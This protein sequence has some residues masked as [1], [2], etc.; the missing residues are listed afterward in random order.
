M[1]HIT[2]PPQ[3]RYS[4]LSKL[5]DVELAAEM[6]YLYTR[7]IPDKIK[8]VSTF[9]QIFRHPTD[10]KRLRETFQVVPA[11]KHVEDLQM[12]VERMQAISEELEYR[13]I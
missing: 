9:C 4:D 13:R 8:T 1:G 6:E 2:A 7:G 3:V 10:Y 12:M 5:T 11:W